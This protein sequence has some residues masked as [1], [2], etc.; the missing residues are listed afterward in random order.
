MREKNRARKI[1][2]EENYEH[3][4]AESENEMPTVYV[5]QHTG[6]FNREAGRFE[7]LDLSDAERLGTLRVLMDGVAN[8]WHPTPDSMKQLREVLKDYDGIAGDSILPLGDITLIAAVFGVIGSM[9]P[10]VN[11]CRYDRHKKRYLM[12]PIVL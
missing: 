5:T 12:V 3:E 7:L 2:L 1:F 8:S 10:K 11:V 6:R 9:A 4:S